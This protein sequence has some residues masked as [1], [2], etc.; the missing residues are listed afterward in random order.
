[1]CSIAVCGSEDRVNAVRRHGTGTI[2]GDA[3][4]LRELRDDKLGTLPFGGVYSV[5]IVRYQGAPF[6]TM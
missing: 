1:M 6:R 5:G 2:E 4:R 3:G